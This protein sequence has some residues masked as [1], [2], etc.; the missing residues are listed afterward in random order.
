[1]RNAELSAYFFLAPLDSSWPD[2]GRL[3]PYFDSETVESAADDVIPDTRKVFDTTSADEDDRVL[4]K[5]MSFTWDV[6]DDFLAVC[7]ANLCDFAQRGVR[8]FWRARHH[9]H[10]HAAALRALHKRG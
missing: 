3:A 4:L 5:V 1:M 10:A 8:F 9:L 2:F 6:G 7:E